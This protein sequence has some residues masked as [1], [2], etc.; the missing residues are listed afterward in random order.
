MSERDEMRRLIGVIEKG[1]ANA[2]VEQNVED[3][4]LFA[5]TV[6]FFANKLDAKLKAGDKRKKAAGGAVT[7][8]APKQRSAQVGSAPTSVTTQSALPK[9]NST[10]I[11]GA[12]YD[13]VRNVAAIAPVPTQPAS[14]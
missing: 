1:A 8:A 13:R 5:N 7:K 6:S 2:T 3:L 11:S 10:A 14:A 4:R 12:D 9:A